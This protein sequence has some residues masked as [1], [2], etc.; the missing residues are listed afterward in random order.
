M[1]DGI[2]PIEGLRMEIRKMKSMTWP[3]RFVQFTTYWLWKTVLAVIFIVAVINLTK[4]FILAQ[5]DVIIS[6][7]TVNMKTNDEVVAYLT[8]DYMTHVGGTYRK[9]DIWLSSGN[10]MEFTNVEG[11]S[12]DQTYAWQSLYTMLA[13]RDLDY[14]ILDETS[15]EGLKNEGLYVKLDTV[16]PAELLESISDRTEETEGYNAFTEQNET[17]LYGIRLDG[18]PI[19]EQYG[20]QPDTAWLVF[21]TNGRN[22]DEAPAFVEYLL[23]TENAQ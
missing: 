6:G 20:M 16:L 17:G 22:L 23:Q 19:F 12:F 1:A 3:E 13:N 4:N 11:A 15:F 9:Q 18:L 8:D 7:A 2:G 14:M 21:V 5:R 10:F